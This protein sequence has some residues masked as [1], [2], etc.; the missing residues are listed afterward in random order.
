MLYDGLCLLL[1]AVFRVLFTLEYYG[2]EH[3]PATGP[4]VIAG[5]HPS[6]L[7]PVLI[8]ISAPRRVYFMAWD[9][10]FKVPLLGYL[11]HKFGAFPVRLGGGDS[12]AY[13]AALE[14]LQS[15][16]ILGIFPEAGRSAEG[17]MNPL[18]TGAAR[19]ALETGAPIV[20]VTITGA[21]DA[22]PSSRRLPWPRKITVKFH[23]PRHFTADELE[24]RDDKEF[25]QRVTAELRET[26]ERRLLPSLQ[27]D[28]RKSR[29]FA[30]P[31]SP[32]RIYELD[33]LFAAAVAVALGGP[34][35]PIL[36]A[37]LGHF[38]YLLADIWWIPQGRLT[39]AVR[40][41]STPA[42]ALA[43]APLFA[44]SVGVGGT[45]WW[46]LAALVCGL[47]MCFNWTNHYVAQRFVRGGLLSFLLA[48]VLAL[49][50]PVP[51]GPHLAFASFAIVATVWWRALYWAAGAGAAA[52][53]GFAL[54]LLYEATWPQIWPWL[55]LGVATTLYTRVVKFS[56]HDGRLI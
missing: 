12:N 41:L 38:G 17:H 32:I 16:R 9:A 11:I 23:P 55:C 24:R 47:A 26:I 10:L 4:V 53:Y 18:K 33:V 45:E 21:F 8:S 51:F 5:N 39:K 50:L 19:L 14:V 48:F 42:V 30:G 44:A 37:A 34:A 40:E 29:A 7:D 25:Q 36:G 13:S 15:G 2:A 31:A 22:W 54:C 27:A 3:I 6:Y 52:A 28:A 1:H 49:W 46:S 35:M 20:P 56:A 43:M